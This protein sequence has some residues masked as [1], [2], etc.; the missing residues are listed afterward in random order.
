[1][2]ISRAVAMRSFRFALWSE[3][4]KALRSAVPWGTA[5]GFC[6][7]P[8]MGGF[9]MIIL[10][11]PEAARSMGLISTKARLTAGTADWPA[12]FSLLA[13]GAAVGGAVLFSILT[14]WVFGR[15]FSDRTVK[16]LLAV[17]TSRSAIVSAKFVVIAILSIV[18]TALVLGLGLIVGRLVN[19]PGWSASLMQSSLVDI[20]GAALLS[21]CLL[22][23]VALV[24][25]MGRGYLP[26]FGWLILTIALAQVAAIT[27][28]GDWFPWAVPA[29]FSGAAGP[30]SG[31]LGLHS[32][33]AVLL[34]SVLG[35][36]LVYWW[37]R[38]ADQAR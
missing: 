37:W 22:P 20:S 17:P 38:D 30:R 29:L 15:E 23:Y 27:G 4:L 36:A 2:N 25:S 10:K 8:L 34:A 16:E 6:L 5:L 24:A 12:F 35:L 3:S 13:Q 11:D 14:S 18:I 21:I 33:I 28:W 19:I 9:F 1:M 7:I 32:Y 31:V 26:A